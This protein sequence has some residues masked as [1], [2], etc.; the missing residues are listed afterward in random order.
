MMQ[1]V[2]FHLKDRRNN[3]VGSFTSF[4]KSRKSATSRGR[5]ILK[6]IAAGFYEGGVFHPIRDSADYDPSR[7]SAPRARRTEKRRATRKK[8]SQAAGRRASTRARKARRG[9]IS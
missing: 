9:S 2:T 7:L 8:K 3:P 5:R 4:G 1:R 6:N